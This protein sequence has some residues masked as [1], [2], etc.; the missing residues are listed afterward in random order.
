M[1]KG[2]APPSEY[3]VLAMEPGK[4]KG[5]VSAK[6]F[7]LIPIFNYDEQLENTLL[8]DV[9]SI[10]PGSPDQVVNQPPPKNWKKGKKR[11]FSGKKERLAYVYIQL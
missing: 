5:A 3:P 7:Y 11:D 4:D 1:K 6:R 9:A 8:L 10:N 2:E